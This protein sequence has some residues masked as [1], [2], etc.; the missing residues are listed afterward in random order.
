[1]RRRNL[2]N[3]IHG[4]IFLLLVAAQANSRVAFT[5]EYR[6]G[7]P[8]PEALLCRPE[9][10][11]PFPAVVHN[12]GAGVDITGY[13]RA[14]LRGYDLPGI[15]RELSKAGF[16]TFIP[17]RKGG[18][19]PRNIPPH[20]AQVL[21]AIDHVK[22]MPN[23]DPSRIAVIGNSRGGLLTLMVGVERADLK[24]LVTMA[25]AETGGN[26]ANALSQVS[27]L[28]AP[29]LLLVEKSDESVFQNNFDTIDRV[30][31]ENKKGVKSIRYDQGGGHDLFHGVRYYLEDVKKFLLEKLG[32][33]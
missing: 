15:C 7:G 31:R 12:H 29:V 32:D 28:N 17:I 10:K 27:S 23:V 24:A 21:A 1:M 14:L 6:I 9:G 33:K 4:L 25:P 30:L 20:K 2:A 11:G 18:P 8:D 3:A 16:L 26:L 22:A 5:A 13:P 19:G